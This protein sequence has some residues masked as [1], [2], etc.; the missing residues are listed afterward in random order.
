MLGSF[1]ATFLF[2]VCLFGTSEAQ[3]LP[4]VIEI[5][6]D[7]VVTSNST[8]IT[9][10]VK[11]LTSAITVTLPPVS[12]F[13]YLWVGVMYSNCT[14]EGAAAGYFVTIA[15]DGDDQVMNMGSSITL[16]QDCTFFRLVN[17]GIDTWMNF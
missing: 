9:L 14:G 16:Y 1:L 4:G 11:A 3:G 6:S 13:T 12:N 15:A 10:L 2:S 8:D 5:D 7:Y 17:D